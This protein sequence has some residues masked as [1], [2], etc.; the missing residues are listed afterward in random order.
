MI[1]IQTNRVFAQRVIYNGWPLAIFQPSDAVEQSMQ[2]CFF[3]CFNSLLLIFILYNSY[4]CCV[5]TFHYWCY[6]LVIEVFTLSKH[7]LIRM[8]KVEYCTSCLPLSSMWVTVYVVKKWSLHWLYKWH[9]SGGGDMTWGIKWQ[10]C[11]YS[12][13]GLEPVNEMKVLVLGV[14]SLRA[15]YSYLSSS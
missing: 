11:A 6:S 15:I 12:A 8:H 1:K 10:F 3:C 13:P 5:V 2:L 9:F 4:Y 14:A 7:P